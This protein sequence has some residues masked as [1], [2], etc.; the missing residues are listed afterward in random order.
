MAQTIS[1]SA[2]DLHLSRKRPLTCAPESDLFW[3]LRGG[4]RVDE[5]LVKGRSM[6][7]PLGLEEGEDKEKEV[8]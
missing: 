8:E 6:D 3:T 7:M 2:A 5:V 4:W 1:W